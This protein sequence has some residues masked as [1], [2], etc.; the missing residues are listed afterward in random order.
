MCSPNSAAY[1]EHQNWLAQL[2]G[3]QD[4]LERSAG[5]DANAAAAAR[6]A[7][8]QLEEQQQLPSPHFSSPSL[9]RARMA[10]GEQNALLDAEFAGLALDGD[11]FDVPV[12][13]S[14]GSFSSGTGISPRFTADDLEADFEPPVYRGMGAPAPAPASA[15]PE[16]DAEAWLA[17]MP[18]LIRRQ[19]AGPL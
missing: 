19:R 8:R 15:A 6:A 2:R 18:P 5:G 4:A 14:L 1:E 9:P 11:D 16:L 7:M 12:Y 10:W 3:V 17:A 13:R